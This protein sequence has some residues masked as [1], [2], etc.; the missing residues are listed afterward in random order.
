MRDSRRDPD[1]RRPYSSDA[2]PPRWKR[3]AG[4]R[5]KTVR[6]GAAG[7]V[8]GHPRDTGDDRRRKARWSLWLADLGVLLTGLAQMVPDDSRQ[9]LV[10]LVVRV[11]QS[12]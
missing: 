2:L 5:P 1:A 7:D 10:E 11:I 6:S 9:Q 4:Y 8:T 3:L 12:L